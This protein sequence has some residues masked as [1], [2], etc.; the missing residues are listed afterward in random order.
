[1]WA[2]FQSAKFW[3]TLG[4]ILAGTAVMLSAYGSHILVGGE[5]VYHKF[6]LSVQYHMWHALG[7]LAVGWQCSI[8]SEPKTWAAFSGIFFTAGIFLFS[9]N[10]Y[11]FAI[12]G[13]QTIT[14]AMPVGGF[15]FIGGWILLALAS[16]MQKKDDG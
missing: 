6:M 9:G 1:M 7:L 15:C 3:T 10:L 8:G 13:N 5:E 4:A 2:V 14:A 12:T 16:F 11:V